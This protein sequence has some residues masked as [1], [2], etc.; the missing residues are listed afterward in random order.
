[1]S[2]EDIFIVCFILFIVLIIVIA[3]VINHI[4]IKEI[5]DSQVRAIGNAYDRIDAILDKWQKQ[6]DERGKN[7]RSRD[8]KI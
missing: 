3:V 7:D 5:T 1:M 6:K 4:A 2:S 8:K